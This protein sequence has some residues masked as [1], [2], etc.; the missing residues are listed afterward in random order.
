[1]KRIFEIDA[2]GQ[3]CQNGKVATFLPNIHFG[4]FV[5]VHR[6]QKF[7]LSNDFSLSVIKDLFY[8]F[9]KKVSQVLSMAVHV[10]IKED[11]LN[12]F[13]FPSLDFKNSFC[14]E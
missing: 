6:F 4:T 13:K 3:K 5:P 2:Q 11:K 7:L 12:Y 8:T 1:V 9:T 14:F 10:L